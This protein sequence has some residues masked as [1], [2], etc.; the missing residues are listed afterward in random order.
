M[1]TSLIRKHG[2]LIVLCFC[3]SACVPWSYF[4]PSLAPEVERSWSITASVEPLQGEGSASLDVSWQKGD[5]IKVF[6]AD[7]PEGLVYELMELDEGKTTG[8]FLGDT[9]TGDGPFYAVYPA[10]QV[11]GS[12]PSLSLVIPPVQIYEPGTLGRGASLAIAKGN[13]LGDLQ[14]RSVGGL[15]KV[16]VKGSGTLKTVNLYATD[17]DFLQGTAGLDLDAGFPA[18]VIPPVSEST[19][20]VSLEVGGAKLNLGGSPFYIFLPAEALSGRFQVEAIDTEGKAM[21]HTVEAAASGRIE[22]ARIHPLPAFSYRPRY[23]EDFLTSKDLACAGTGA[24][25]SDTWAP[26]VSFTRQSGQYMR[27]EEEDWKTAGIQDWQSRH[28]VLL[29]VPLDL[30]LDASVEADVKVYGNFDGIDSGS[31][32]LR[33]V[34]QFGPRTWLVDEASGKGYIIR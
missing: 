15:L 34:K 7:H 21:L 20:A 14:F 22:R 11:V 23:Q 13:S 32:S 28:A 31:A 24:A 9:L 5:K 17:G 19:S 2:W 6:N 30:P 10:S 25:Q 4:Y 12:L 18:L 26:F 3:L 16:T 33:V 1:K 8:R 27:E 29:T